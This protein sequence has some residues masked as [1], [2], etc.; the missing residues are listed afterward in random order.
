RLQAVLGALPSPGQ[1]RSV[2]FAL[3]DIASA[4]GADL[5]AFVVS[6]VTKEISTVAPAYAGITADYLTF[7]T[8]G[9]GVVVPVEGATQPLGYIPTDRSVPVV[10]D[11]FTLHM[12]Q[13]LYDDGVTT[14]HAPSVA[15]LVN[16]V[17]ARLNPKDAAT[18]AV[19][20]GD[21]VLVAGAHTFIVSLDAQV[22][23]GSVVVPFN[24]VDTKGIPAVPAVTV[25]AVREAT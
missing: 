25:E 16:P 19:A 17:V 5:K 9:T 20:D 10:T 15:G 14:R 18:I 8:D 6:A 2:A 7:A 21:S 11:R 23:Q 4:M 3:N 22:A 13:S 1:T 12:P 24:Q